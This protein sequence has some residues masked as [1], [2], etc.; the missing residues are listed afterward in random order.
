MAV[1]EEGGQVRRN[2]IRT[3]RR[4]TDR[5]ILSEFMEGRR[6]EGRP[7]TWGEVCAA[8]REEELQEGRQPAQS[9]EAMASLF[10]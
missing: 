9:P 7:K 5:A 4:R 2:P 8:K 1:P 3:N 6:I 10:E